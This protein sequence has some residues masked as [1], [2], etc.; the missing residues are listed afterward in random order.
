MKCCLIIVGS[1][2]IGV[3]NW[4]ICYGKP[5]H[6]ELFV[7][8]ILLQAILLFTGY[9]MYACIYVCSVLFASA[10]MAGGMYVFVLSICPCVHPSAHPTVR[11]VGIEFQ[12]NINHTLFSSGH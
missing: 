8:C 1:S 12:C 2:E 3:I 6:H 9:Y 11:N 7:H 4:W 10:Q 5:E